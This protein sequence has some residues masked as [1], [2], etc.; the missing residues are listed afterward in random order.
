MTSR[1]HAPQPR[2]VR[3]A[4]LRPSARADHH[5]QVGRRPTARHSHRGPGRRGPPAEHGRCPCRRQQHVPLLPRGVGPERSVRDLHVPL[6]RVA[7][8]SEGSHPRASNERVGCAPIRSSGTAGRARVRSEFAAWW[9]S[10]ASWSSSPAAASR[11]ASPAARVACSSPT[12]CSN[13]HARSA[14]TELI[15]VIWAGDLPANHASALTVL[16]SKLHAAV[17]G[18]GPRRSRQR[19]RRFAARRPRRCRTGAGRPAPCR[20]GRRTR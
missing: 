19:A 14:A 12:S 17:G 7:S 16:L 2:D 5:G 18:G 1:A 20:V 10:G 4:R 8:P 6:P 9:W 13:G 15:E 11:S 3:G